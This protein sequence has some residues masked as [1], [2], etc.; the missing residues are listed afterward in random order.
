MSTAEQHLEHIPDDE[1]PPPAGPVEHDVPP[2]D[3]PPPAH[4]SSAVT[5]PSLFGDDGSAELRAR[6]DDVQVRFVDDPRDCVHRADGLVADAVRQLTDRFS[7][8]RERLEQQWERGEEAST[9]D[10][11]ITL[12]RYRDFFER[13]LAV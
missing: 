10:L 13:L 6:W 7:D 8:A 2:V 11:R 3:S 12:T 5:E 4:P 1:V 9:E